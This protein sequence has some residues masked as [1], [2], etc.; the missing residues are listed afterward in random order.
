MS[1]KNWTEDELVFSLGYYFFVYQHNTRLDDVKQFASELTKKTNKNRTYKAIKMRFSNFDHFNDNKKTDGYENC[2]E[3]C[4]I[5]WRA[6]TKNSMPT[7]QL[8]KKFYE[9]VKN[10]AIDFDIY[11]SFL[12][13]YKELIGISEETYD[14]TTDNIVDDV[15]V[16]LNFIPKERPALLNKH[17]RAQY[18]R[19]SN[20][21]KNVIKYY[22]FKCNIDETHT[23]FTTR[24]G[25]QYME[26][27]HLIPFSKQDNFEHSIDCPANIVCLCPN[28]HRKLHYGANIDEELKKL[29]SLRKKQ[30]EASGIN[31]SFD[32]LKNMYR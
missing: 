5:V 4:E 6:Y 8:I 31:I 19:D 3:L 16:E 28:C 2:G 32:D 27:H 13:E 21:A 23:S 30:L 18:K 29:Y 24:N 14:V 9:F 26:A 1:R 10:Y 17:G 25:H 7:I 22:K 11:E 15:V 20:E 12:N